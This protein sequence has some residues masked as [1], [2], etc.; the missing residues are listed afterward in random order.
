MCG[1]SRRAQASLPRFAPEAIL[2]FRLLVLRSAVTRQGLTFTTGSF[3]TRFTSPP[4]Q[5]PRL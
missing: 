5:P 2:T 3:L 1:P 4:D